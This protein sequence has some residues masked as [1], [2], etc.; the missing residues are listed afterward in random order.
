VVGGGQGEKG[1][2][3]KFLDGR[4]CTDSGSEE[5]GHIP[6]VLPDLYKKGKSF[7]GIGREKGA[8]YGEGSVWLYWVRAGRGK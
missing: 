1:K 7:W 3:S 8:E 5:E 6:R 2:S 4:G